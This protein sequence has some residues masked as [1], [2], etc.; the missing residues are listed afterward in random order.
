MLDTTEVKK[1]TQL[2]AA[3]VDKKIDDTTY[4]VTSKNFFKAN[5][6][7][8]LIGPKHSLY[9]VKIK[10]IVDPQGI[11]YNVVNQPAK[12]FIIT[13]DKPLKDVGYEDI[14]RIKQ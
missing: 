6:N 3:F 13:F 5:Q 8:E 7:F 12:K 4:E 11:K 2:Y 14:L 1:V 10:Q 9:D